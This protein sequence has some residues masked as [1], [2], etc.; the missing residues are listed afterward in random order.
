MWWVAPDG[1]VYDHPP[2]EEPP[3]EHIEGSS[4]LFTPPENNIFQDWQ[5]RRESEAR[6]KRDEAQAKYW[7]EK[8]KSEKSKRQ[9]NNPFGL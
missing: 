1:T 4:P 3:F 7:E 9:N 8:A 6:I 5:K 2:W